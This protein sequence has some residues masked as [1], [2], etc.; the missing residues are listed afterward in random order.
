VEVDAKH[1]VKND[2]KEDARDDMKAWGYVNFE[3]L[4]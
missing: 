3:Q 1:D 2:I 4:K